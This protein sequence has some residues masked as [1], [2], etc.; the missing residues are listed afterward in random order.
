MIKK[1][2]A[3]LAAHL[4]MMTEL[5]REDHSAAI[6]PSAFVIKC[7]TLAWHTLR[8]AMSHDDV[9]TKTE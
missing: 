8:G 7:A 2:S 4:S 6:A 9:V 3:A 1:R 5:F